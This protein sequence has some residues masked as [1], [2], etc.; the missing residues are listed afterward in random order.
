MSRI[1]VH[2]HF[3]P[4]LDDGCQS[5][6]ESLACLRMLAGAGYGRVFCTPHSGASGFTELT[7]AEVAQRVLRLQEQVTVA[8]IPIELKPGGE[9]RLT[10]ELA[11][12]LPGGIVPT[13]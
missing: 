7:P 4:N 13:Y 8:G 11:T 9:V 3:L 1:D 6:A 10:P 5:V 2:G 12:D